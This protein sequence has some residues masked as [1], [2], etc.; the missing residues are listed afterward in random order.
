MPGA[1]KRERYESIH[2]FWATD[3]IPSYVP[4]RNM[5]VCLPKDKLNNALY[6]VIR[7]IPKLEAT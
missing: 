7:N 2:T 6:S 4:N 3:W 1:K 5:Y